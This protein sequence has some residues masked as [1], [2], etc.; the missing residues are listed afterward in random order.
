MSSHDQ[1][2]SPILNDFRN[3]LFLVWAHLSL[4]A[5]T[6]VQYDIAQYLADGPRRRIIEAFR[7]CG[8]SWIT[9][10]FVLWRLLKNPNERILV[11]SASK[12]RAEAF[13]VFCKRLIN[14]MPLLEHLKPREG[15]RDSNLAFDVG[16]SSAHQAP[17][18]RSVGITGQIT[19]GRATLIVGDDVEV[20][21]N[22]LTHGMREKLAEAVKEFDA[23]LV[24]GGE[25]VYLGTPQT[26]SSLYN[27][28]P[29]RGYDLR[30]W[31]VRYPTEEQE[32]RYGDRLAPFI[33]AKLAIGNVQRGASVEAGR[34]TETDLIERELSYG[35]SGF[36]LQFMLDTRA[37]DADRH[38][39]KLSDL[40]LLDIDPA[41]APVQVMWASGPQQKVEDVPC[42][43]LPGDYWFA[44]MWVSKDFA[45]YQGIV[46]AIDP[47]GMGGDEV[48]YAVVGMLNGFLYLLASGGL[49]GGY[50][51]E[52]LKQLAM[53]ARANKV[54]EV[55]VEKNF[56]DGMFLSLLTPYLTKYHPVTTTLIHSTG[57]KERRII[58]TLEPVMNQHRLIVNKKLVQQDIDTT[59]VYA[60]EVAHRYQ[61]FYQLTRITKDR[62]SIPKDDRLDA[63]AMAVK[64]WVNHMDRDV[65]KNE[66][67][68][69]AALLDAELR[70]FVA[71]AGGSLESTSWN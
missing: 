29:T 10:A 13:S 36:A 52:N 20:P 28:L 46:M 65:Q 22:S 57:Q 41:M 17:S 53:I 54:T 23:V 27:V 68:H 63:L 4:P 18:V 42:V 11:V 43:G 15:Q 37:S 25:I 59:D 30:I 48:G 64:Y 38:P 32:A 66:Q 24:P 45:S 51:D 2:F 3:F 34:F 56:G 21:K 47:S 70:A 5:P 67:A 35:R 60:T 1:D 19:G 44:P 71:A 69:R 49:R 55:L 39:L 58:D 8:K 31:P 33:K 61:L 9:A 50:A 12:D 16:P 40:I 14:E 26:E 62:D 7:G 6:E